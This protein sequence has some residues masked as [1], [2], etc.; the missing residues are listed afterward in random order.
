[1]KI[2]FSGD[3]PTVNTGFG[4]VSKNILNRLYE[5]GHEI[6][7]LGVNHYGMPYDQRKFPYQIFPCEQGGPEQVFGFHKYWDLY[8]VVKP[9]ICFFLNDPW[10]IH[11]FVEA[12]PENIMPHTKL[13]GYY[14]TDGG[15]IKKEW[16]ASLNKL[17][18]QVCYSHYAE[19]VITKS[20][21]GKIPANLH[22]IYHGVD[23]SKFFPINQSIARRELGLPDNLFIIGMVARNQFRKR[24]DI[25]MAAFTEFAEGKDDVKLYLHTALDDIGYDIADLAR[26]FNL[27]DKMIL[28]EDITSARGVSDERLNLIYNSFDVNA[29]ISL[30]D[31]FGLPVAESMATGCPQLVSDHSCLKEL[32]D[33]HGGLT[34]KTESWI[35][36]TSGINTW[37]GISSYKDIA[38][39]LEILYN[40]RE[41]RIKLAEQAYEFIMQEKFTWPYVVDHFERIMKDLLHIL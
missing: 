18:A 7:V 37:G 25:L 41:L 39:K 35:L 31:G 21:E 19:G 17:D 28:T 34:V 8:N 29:L 13:I 10:L 11:K 24:F 23:T 5:R 15:P 20:N 9:D 22:Q 36:N 12:K 16:M 4:I 6:V 30:G 33:G 38:E 14:P 27:Q 1:M 3:T 2:L 40:N 26:Q 32:V